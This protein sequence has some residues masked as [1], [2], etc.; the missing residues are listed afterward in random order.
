MGPRAT[1]DLRS[2]SLIMAPAAPYFSPK[3][4]W[5]NKVI[6]KIQTTC[7]NPKAGYLGVIQKTAVQENRRI[8][9]VNHW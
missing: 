7:D 8:T 2:P 9:T 6:D 5:N 1:Q 3:K 4:E